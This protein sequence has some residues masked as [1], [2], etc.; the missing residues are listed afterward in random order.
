MPA[1]LNYKALRLRFDCQSSSI[2]CENV[3]RIVMM[4][5]RADAI[6]QEEDARFE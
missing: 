4:H 3:G 2:C 1:E 6:R 5:F